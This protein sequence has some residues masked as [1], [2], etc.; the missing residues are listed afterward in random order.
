MKTINLVNEEKCFNCKLCAWECPKN[1]I[2]FAENEY[3]FAYPHINKELCIECGKC[4]KKC[5]LQTI[6]VNPIKAVY[7]AVSQEKELLIKSASGGAFATIAKNVLIRGEVVYG[8]TLEKNE[9]L[10]L[11]AKHIRIESLSDLE[12][13]QGSKYVQ[14]N[15]EGVFSLLAEDIKQGKEIVFS[16]TPCQVSAVKSAFGEKENLLLIDIICHGVPS[17][18][19]FSDYLRLLA[20]K[21]NQMEDFYFR[22]KDSGWGLCA[23]IKYKDKKG[24]TKTKLL[25]CNISSYYKLFLQ[26][27]TYR[28]SCYRCNYAQGNRVSDITLGD[29]WGIEKNK[30]LYKALLDKGI[31][32]SKGVSCALACTEKGIKYLK[33]ANLSLLDSDFESVVLENKQLSSPSVAP[34][35]RQSVMENY[36]NNG[37]QAV[38]KNFQKKLGLKKYIII[39]KNKVSPKWKA[40]LKKL[41]KR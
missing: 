12:K 24:K 2:T 21:H 7:S 28:E 10:I 11:Q 19:M 23:K 8:A 30:S 15:I 25:P 35:S 41:L 1:A 17:Q 9:E 22:S 39:L 40:R 37:Y 32:V 33:E 29:Y 18:K 13:L 6:N 38:D 16:G 3:G 34:K 27:V 31:D 5:P 26:S 20:K 14:S 36:K 4:L